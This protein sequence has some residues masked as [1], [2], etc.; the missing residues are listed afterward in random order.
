M[1]EPGERAE[2]TEVASGLSARGE[3][4]PRRAHCRTAATNG[5]AETS[6]GQPETLPLFGDMAANSSERVIQNVTR[7]TALGYKEL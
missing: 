3:R 6:S 7:I 2:I 4:R 1:A 5:D